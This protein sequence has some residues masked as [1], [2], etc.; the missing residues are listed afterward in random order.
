MPCALLGEQL[1]GLLYANDMCMDTVNVNIS[2]M[3][4]QEN[5]ICKGFCKGPKYRFF[6]YLTQEASETTLGGWKTE[7]QLLL[8]PGWDACWAECGGFVKLLFLSPYFLATCSPHCSLHMS[9]A[10]QW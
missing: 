9:H 2:R 5:T 1:R 6:L 8:E 10:G 4:I 7:S 3:N